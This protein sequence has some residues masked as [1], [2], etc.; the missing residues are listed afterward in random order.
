LATFDEIVHGR[1]SI[2]KY[3]HG[4]V[5]DPL[6]REILDLARHAPTSMN[7]QACCFVV[8]RDAE[9]RRRLAEIK[10][11]HCPPEKRDYPADFLADAPVIIAVCVERGRAFG[12]EIENGVLASAFL[13]LAA[14]SRGLAGVF[15]TAYNRDDPALAAS[16]R[17]LLRL[18]DGVDPVTLV[19]LGYPDAEPAAKTLRPLKEIVHSL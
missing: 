12:R 13:L 18:P 15:L 19:P 1:R 10:N 2:R 8:I 17:A 5:P 16:I 4:E 7:G 14:S 6:V 11:L 9:I 3:D